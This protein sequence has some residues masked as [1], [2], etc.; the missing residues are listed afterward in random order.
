MD[1]TPVFCKQEGAQCILTL[2][3]PQQFNALSEDVLDALQTTLNAV[4][5]DRS[6]R[7]LVIESASEKAFCAGHD[8]KQMRANPDKRAIAS[9]GPCRL[10]ID[11]RQRLPDPVAHCY[12]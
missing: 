4:A 1:T 6:I 11:T 9:T 2:N 8:L 10:A 12:D 3:R 7:V 5:N